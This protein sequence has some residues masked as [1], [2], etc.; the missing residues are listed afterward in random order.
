V[1]AAA[2]AWKLFLKTISH[3]GGVPRQQCRPKRRRGYIEKPCGWSADLILML[4]VNVLAIFANLMDSDQVAALIVAD[5]ANC[6][7]Q[8]HTARG[9]RRFMSPAFSTWRW[10]S[11]PDQ[12]RTAGRQRRM[13]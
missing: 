12:T 3:M 6:R 8:I 7:H 9:E 4:V 5:G 10:R 13:R 2:A 1:Q 11:V